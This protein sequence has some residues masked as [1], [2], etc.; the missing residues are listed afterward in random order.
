MFSPVTDN[1][2]VV[3]TYL[4]WQDGLIAGCTFRCED[5]EENQEARVNTCELWFTKSELSHWT[6]L[7]LM[8]D[9]MLWL[10]WMCCLAQFPNKQRAKQIHYFHTHG[11]RREQGRACQRSEAWLWLKVKHMLFTQSGFCWWNQ[12]CDR[13]WQ[14]PG[15]GQTC[16]L[17]SVPAGG[18]ITFTAAWFLTL[19]FPWEGW[20]SL[21]SWQAPCPACH[22][23]RGH[24]ALATPPS[25]YSRRHFWCVWHTRQRQTRSACSQSHPVAARER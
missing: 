18:L 25:L 1:R 19:I 12:H 8:F 14:P 7:E 10:Y 9:L 20:L 2:T 21:R 5:P 11:C 16:P 15:S 6:M 24:Q 13:R 17:C 3:L 23:H 22:S 4:W